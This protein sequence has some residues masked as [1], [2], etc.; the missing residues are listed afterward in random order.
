MEPQNYSIIFDTGEGST[1]NSQT[2]QENKRVTKPTN[3]TRD[4]YTFADWYADEAFATVW[5]FNTPITKD[6]ILYAKWIADTYAVTY[7]ANE[8]T[9]GTVPSIQTKTHEVNLTLAS[10]TGNL[11]RT[12]YS[13]DGWN[14]QADGLGTDYETGSSY[15]ANAEVTL[16]A[17][18][19]ADTYAVTYN[20]NEATSG[21]VPSVQTKTHG[22]NLTLASNTGNLARTG[23]S[24]DGWNTQADGLGTDYETGSS[25]T[26]NAKVTL[27][28]KWI[29]N[30]NTLRFDANAG[31]GSMDSQTVNTNEMIILPANIFTKTGYIFTGWATTSTGDV[32]YT[33]E[34]FFTMGTSDE[35]LYAKWRE[36]AIR[37]IGPSG[38]Y[39]FYDKG[40]YTNGWRYLEAAPYG[41][42]EG[43]TDSK[44]AYVGDDDPHFEWGVHGYTVEPSTKAT[45]VGSGKTNTANIISYHDSLGTLYPEKEDYYTNPK[46]YHVDNDGTVVAKVCADY[47]GGGY[48][49]WFLPSKDELN[50]MYGNLYKA[51]PTLGG[52]SNDIYYWS[53]SEYGANDAWIQYFLYGNQP[54][55][56]RSNSVRVRPVRA[57]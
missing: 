38:G 22:V 46:E 39:V 34:D 28:A 51:V 6:T 1:V 31:S 48:D 11:A 17:K 50:L 9:S 52:F 26:T 16:Y 21:T 33:D 29:A 32:E 27:Y 45:A 49:D 25:Y 3:P 41:W 7:S 54:R 15:T 44:G 30:K 18:W 23:Y 19:I 24:F 8:A 35:T 42:Y 55:Y 53:S 10:N 56:Y 20:A 40:E 57:F 4:G 12:G 36:L 43:V 37:D 14:T 5:D 13:F 2:V 47:R